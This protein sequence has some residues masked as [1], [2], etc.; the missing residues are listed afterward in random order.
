MGA[1]ASR[2][3]GWYTD[4]DDPALIRHWDGRRWGGQRRP[5]PSWAGRVAGREQPSDEERRAQRRRAFFVGVGVLALVATLSVLAAASGKAK[6]PPR[7]VH[8]LA[9]TKAANR[10]CAS[11]MPP[12][13]AQRPQLGSHEDPGPRTKVAHEVDAV[14]DGLAQV[15]SHLRGL[16]VAAADQPEV[17]RWLARWDAYVAVGHRYA[18]ALRRGV[19]AEYTKVAAEGNQP[20]KDVFVFAQ[21]NGMKECRF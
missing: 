13:R 14:A 5:R 17:T 3:P 6:I 11:E 10:L 8:D 2:P 16:R 1:N 9:F 12:W 18:D 4:P 15:A 21:A 7:S 20:S 19:P